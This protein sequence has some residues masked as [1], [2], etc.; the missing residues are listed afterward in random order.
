MTKHEDP[1]AADRNQLGS[2]LFTPRSVALVGASAD[3]SKLASRPQRVLRKHGFTGTIIPINPART[4]INGDRAYPSL[5]SVPEKIDHAFIMVPSAAVPGVIDDCVEAGVKV[6]TIFTAGFAELGEAGRRVQDAM[7]EK[8]R[9]GGVRLI[10]PNCLGVVNVSGHTVLSANAVLESETLHAGHL[11]L[12]SQSGS[13]MGA[14]VSRA[15]TRGLGFSKLVSVGNE[16]DVGVGEIVDCMV[17]DPAT[18]C[19][20]LFLETFRDAPRLGLAARRAYAL[21]KPVIAFKLGRSAVGRQIATTHTGAIVGADD[22]ANAF[23]KDNG[24]IRVETFEALYETAQLVT[25]FKPPKGKRVSVLTGTGGAAAMVVDRLGLTG[26]DVVGPTPKI[27]ADLAL[28]NIQVSDAPLI[29]MPMG[30]GEGKVYSTIINALMDSEHCDAVVA[31]QGSTATQNPESVR[32]RML[33]ATLGAKP[34]AIFLAPQAD[35]AL[36]ILQDSNVAA[37]RTPEACADAVRAYCEWQVPT[38]HPGID[39]QVLKLLNTTLQSIVGAPMHEQAAASALSVLG[40]PFAPSQVIAGGVESVALQFPV[41]AKILSADIPHKTEVG[42]VVLNIVDAIELRTTVDAMLARIAQSNPQAHIEGVLVQSMARGIAE[43]IVGYRRDPDV[44]P[45]VMVG[46]GGVMAELGGGHAVR[47]APV[48]LAEA[49]K[50]IDAVPGFALLRGY[51]NQPKGDLT[52]LAQVIHQL[53]LLVCVDTCVVTEAE[54]NPLLVKSDGVLAV[55]ALLV[56]AAL[57][58]ETI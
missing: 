47:L 35:T 17:D 41:V 24:I 27:M 18:R 5:A 28:Q 36:R 15:Q 12:V 43:V 38:D 58:K 39:P 1:F 22:V 21:G 32:Q 9:Q 34:L 51:R 55:D 6:A 49:H 53:S 14:I 2:A 30:R 46:V 37:F 54:I 11:S 57:N 45:V 4:E 29:D 33:A 56:T 44:G 31:V 3:P 52:A 48:T 40:I 23:F 25:G 19:I 16:C 50:M 42:G 10:G 20:M 13:M 7:V 26:I 8:A